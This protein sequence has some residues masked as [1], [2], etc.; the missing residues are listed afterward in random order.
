MHTYTH[1]FFCI[2]GLVQLNASRFDTPTL[3]P[4]HHMSNKNENHKQKLANFGRMRLAKQ[5][6]LEAVPVKKSGLRE[7][8]I[9]TFKQMVSVEGGTLGEC[10]SSLANWQFPFHR[11]KGTEK[12]TGVSLE[13]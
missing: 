13:K 9:P 7:V 10:G 2:P 5:L 4:S 1:L 6:V 12:G 11:G 8:D 3:T